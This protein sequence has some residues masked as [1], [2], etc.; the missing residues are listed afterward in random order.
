MNKEINQDLIYIFWGILWGVV[1]FLLVLLL[2]LLI[3][4]HFNEELVGYEKSCARINIDSE[5]DQCICPCSE[6]NWLERM[7]N[8]KKTCDGWIVYKNESCLKGVEFSS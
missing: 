5:F 2:G 6:P 4:N 7:F 1:T 8:I 3:L